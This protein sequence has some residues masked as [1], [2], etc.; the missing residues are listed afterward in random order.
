MNR[1]LSL[2]AVV[3]GVVALA[4]VGLMLSACGFKGPLVLPPNPAKPAESAAQKQS[5][6]LPVV[7][8]PVL[9]VVQI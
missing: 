5:M 6:N 9:N 8:Q 2:W 1:H 7:A 4:G 3:R